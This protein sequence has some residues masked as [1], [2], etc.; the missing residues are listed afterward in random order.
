MST[1]KNAH[2]K[3]IVLQNYLKELESIA[4]AFSAGV[5]S[6]FLLKVAA[7]VLGGNLLAVTIDSKFIPRREIEEATEFCRAQNVRHIVCKVDVLNIPS[8]ADNPP[9]RCY[10]CKL[11]IFTE[12]KR[13]AASEGIKNIVEGS[14][15]D[16]LNDYRPGLQAI[17]ELAIK[18]PLQVAE[19]TK[20]EIRELSREKNLPTADK[21]SFACLASRFVYGERLTA[22]NLSKVERAEKFLFGNGIKQC[23]VRM[24][25]EN[26]ARIEILSEDFP[27]FFEQD[28]R[29]EVWAQFKSFGF[30]YVSLDLFGF[31]SGSMNIKV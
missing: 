12:I 18:S 15:M 11:N 27:K 1:E 8:V 19:L 6:S 22:E 16:D 2:D 31:R 21:P 29:R 26:L 3:L 13:I 23:R 20:A 14:N 25:G 5:D 9:N 4:V 24:H 7:E 10:F 17:K 30:D 28:F